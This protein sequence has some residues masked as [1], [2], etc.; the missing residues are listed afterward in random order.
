MTDFRSPTTDIGIQLRHAV[1]I[2]DVLALDAFA[3]YDLETV[4]ALIAEA[5][6]FFDEVL[7]PLNRTSD[8]E[9]ATLEAD[10]TVTVATGFAEA[11]Q[12]MVAAGWTAVG[13]PV[14]YGG[15][16]FPAVV[17]LAIQEMMTASCMSFSLCPMLTG[18]SI[19][20]LLEFGTEEQRETY[21]P[22][23]VTSE[24]SG[25]MNLTE[26]EAGSDVG[27]LTTKAVPNG[28]GSWSISGQ[29]IYITYGDHEMTDNI[30]H[31]VLA[32]TPDAPPGTKGIS[33]FLVPKFLLNEDGSLGE[34]ND[35]GAVALEHKMGIM[36]SPT[37]VMAYGDNDGATG[38]LIGEEFGGM[39]AM[40]VMMNNARLG[41]GIQG[42][43]IAERAYQQ[44]LAFA[45]ER[46]Q[47]RAP[48]AE[49]GAPSPIVDHADVQR[50]LLDMASTIAA[51][52]G[53]CYRTAAAADHAAHAPDEGERQAAD[54]LAALLTPLAKAWCTDMGC[55]IA[56]TG[57][58]IHGGMGYI[59]ETGAAQH[60]RDARI[61]PIYEGTNGIQALDLVG[62]KLPLGDGAVIASLLASIADTA[63]RCAE[64]EEL[65]VV[66]EHLLAAHASVAEATEWLLSNGPVER[67]PGA[68][69]YLEMLAVTTAGAT[70]ADSALS[71]IAAGAAEVEDRAVLARFFALHKVAR[72]SGLA[73]A[74]T[75][76]GADLA[77][78]RAAVLAP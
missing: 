37:A 16:G 45:H 5:G 4:D 53:L 49:P 66:A 31:L 15:G 42:V 40:F 30:V 52:R 73:P 48:G 68:T 14:E 34:R 24:W 51:M 35:L 22:K 11:Y 57:L 10:G 12:Q 26:P 59:E 46:R 27:A 1:G 74:V 56:S 28:D 72:V 77:A 47:G 63:D 32:R 3:E 13:A 38:W 58:Q 64:H 36:A 29:K 17:N 70:L 20:A 69:P 44:A 75:S 76:L 78:G 23:L 18:G 71:V 8:K 21:L 67:M 65:A 39:R 6:R 7:A 9:G 41:V 25:T 43:A 62:R 33:L 54:A 61:A 55:E 60:F 2:D 50:M 19:D